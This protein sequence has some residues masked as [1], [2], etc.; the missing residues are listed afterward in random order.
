MN[1]F[2]EGFLWGGATAANQCEGG[3]DL[4]G[5]GVSCAEMCTNGAHKS[6]SGS[7]EP[8]SRMRF[9]PPTTELIFTTITR[10]TLPCLRRWASNAT[11]FPSTGPGFT[12]PASRRFPMKRAF[13]FMK[14]VIDECLKYGIEPL[15]TLSHYE[16]PFAMCRESTAGL[17]AGLSNCS[18]NT[19]A[20][21]SDALKAR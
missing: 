20:R 18:S 2:P 12:Q 16:M 9:I 7:P 5:K 10:K 13:S 15:I 19:R 21:C 3:W 8:L 1:G 11:A 17:T 14:N 6:P 4:D